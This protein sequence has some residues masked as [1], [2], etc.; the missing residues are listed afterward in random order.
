MLLVPQSRITLAL[1][2]LNLLMNLDL[3]TAL[4]PC[5]RRCVVVV[6]LVNDHDLVSLIASFVMIDDYHGLV[7]LLSNLMICH[8]GL[9]RVILLWM[10]AV[11]AKM[12]LVH[13]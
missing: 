10:V 13:A 4:I 12:L 9:H 5:I 1:R 11:A 6:I 7:V 2:L 8:G 3:I